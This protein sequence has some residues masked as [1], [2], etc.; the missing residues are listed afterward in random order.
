MFSKALEYDIEMLK[1]RLTEIDNA[2]GY[3]PCASKE[4][5]DRVF[6]QICNAI[7]IKKEINHPCFKITSIEEGLIKDI[8]SSQEDDEE[9]IGD[10]D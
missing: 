5:Y 2:I 8:V 3:D 4:L 10:Y 1:I 6:L 9:F 7:V